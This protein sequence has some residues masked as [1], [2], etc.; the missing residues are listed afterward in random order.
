MAPN[1]EPPTLGEVLR[2]LDAVTQQMS[3]LAIEMK[4]DRAA[5]AATYV[6]R[7]VY[8]AEQ[9]T[10]NAVVADLHR[11]IQAL[12]T[13]HGREI[14]ALKDERRADADKRRQMWLAIS[15]MAVTLTLGL[16]G[17]I[18]NLTR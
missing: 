14:K 10:S 1:S 18:I 15:A 2:R 16:A 6:R 3:N 17:L 7:D 5:L 11:D 13:T 4:E 9:T 8:M 12:E